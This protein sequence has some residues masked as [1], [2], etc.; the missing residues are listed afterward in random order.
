MG[1]LTCEYPRVLTTYLTLGIGRLPYQA[2]LVNLPPCSFVYGGYYREFIYSTVYVLSLPGFKW[3]LL[4]G[5][6]DF[7][8]RFFQAC[9]VIGDGQRQ[10]L[11]W[12][13][14]HMA[15]INRTGSGFAR[16]D[17]NPRGLAIFDLAEGEWK[18][19]YDPDA[20]PYRAHQSV[21]EFHTE[22]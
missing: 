4:Y 10:L 11:S 20:A 7:E 1:P 8:G 12:G 3:T 22:E 18:T 17:R 6:H 16:G 9:A 13:G 19:R 21:S 2:M 14:T 15:L 5:Q